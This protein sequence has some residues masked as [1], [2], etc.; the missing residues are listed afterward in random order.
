MS[1]PSTGFVFCCFNGNQ[2]ILPEIFDLWMRV[3]AQTP[4]S[5]L[6]LLQGT[7]RATDNLR[8]EASLRGISPDRIVFAVPLEPREHLA[9]IKCADLFLDTLPYNAHTTASD[10]LWADVPVLTCE[11]ATFAGR[12]ASSLLHAIDLED[13]VTQTLDEYERMAIQLARTPSMV[14]EIR[15]RLALNRMNAPLFDTQQTCRYIESA[16]TTVMKR[17]Y[18]DEAPVS[19]AVR[20]V[21]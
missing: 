20:D 1:L 17:F 14:A 16:F 13:L 4:G 19:F 3:L 15:S 6:W 2:K 7:Q 9:R 5:V 10:A 12:V 21:I 18:R 11:G 8:R